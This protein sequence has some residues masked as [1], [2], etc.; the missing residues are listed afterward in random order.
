MIS[1]SVS[2]APIHEGT[3]ESHV[4]KVKTYQENTATVGILM[5][6]KATGEIRKVRSLTLNG[7]TRDSHYYVKFSDKTGQTD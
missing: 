6:N 7:K 1:S 4:W 3:H 5:Y 2:P